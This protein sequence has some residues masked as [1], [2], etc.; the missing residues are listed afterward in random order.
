MHLKN[1][2]SFTELCLQC[3]K[4]ITNDVEWKNHCQQQVD[5]YEELPAQFNQI[6]YRYTPA[7]AAQCMFCLFNPKLLTTIRYKQYKNIHYWKEH[8][9]NHF[10]G[11]EMAHISTIDGS[12]AVPCPDPRYSLAFSSVDELRYHSQDAHCCN[13]QKFTTRG[14]TSRALSKE[15]P[16]YTSVPTGLDETTQM[17]FVNETVKTLPSLCLD[18]FAPEG[19]TGIKRKRGRPRKHYD[20]SSAEP[21]SPAPK[22]ALSTKTKRG[23]PK[24]CGSKPSLV[25]PSMVQ[26]KLGIK[27]T[28]ERPTRRYSVSSTGSSY[29]SAS[30]QIHDVQ[31]LESEDDLD[32]SNNESG[33]ESEYELVESSG[34]QFPQGHYWRCR[35]QTAGCDL[36]LVDFFG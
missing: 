34:P 20:T 2:Y 27:R 6:K 12:K 14:S 26:G 3:D 19:H 31:Y 9:N 4:W 30:S 22:G 7:T 11:L 35:I 23:R 28:R 10:L 17:D 25:S 36:C 1:K 32:M 15:D 16:N 18:S 24:K 21:R 29:R 13:L 5:N 8:L 33:S